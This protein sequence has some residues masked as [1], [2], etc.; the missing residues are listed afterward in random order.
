M[1]KS[2]SAFRATVLIGWIVLCV[3]GIL[4][5]RM[6]GV[7][8]WAAGPALAAFLVAFPFY[9]APGF[10]AARERIGAA[11]LP[12]FLVASAVLPYLICTMG[13]IPFR[14]ISV[15]QLVAVALAFGLWYF[16]LPS[17]AASDL[18]FLALFALVM[19]GNYFKD[20]YPTPFP[21]VE[22]NIIGRLTVFESA[23]L[24]LLVA[25][26]EPDPGYGFWPTPKEWKIGVLHFLYF[27]PIGLP[28]A[29]AIQAV[30][31][32]PP[33]PLWLS[34]GT[35][36]GFLW[37]VALAEEFLF[38]GVIQHWME[39]W[40]GSA[41]W[42]LFITAAIFGLAHLPFRQFP[43]W[44]WVLVAGTLGWFCGR[45]RNQAGGIRAGVVTHA[46][47]VTAWRTFF[48]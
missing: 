16:V 42:A 20:V 40:T 35:F 31:F 44:R 15:A 32:S 26:H 18:G 8:F 6:R 45:A 21:K 43:N 4:Y 2:L 9:L 29:L 46:L 30:R 36:F 7:P 41:G 1:P 47:V 5:A 25:R 13:A 3:T 22:I 10:P 34:L 27:I 48:K 14:W 17:C 38:R 33:A 11:R 19:L 39:R 12:L 23:V 28:V 37:V 24:A